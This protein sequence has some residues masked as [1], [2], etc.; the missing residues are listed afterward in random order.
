MY[1]GDSTEATPI[2]IP[3]TIQAI[4]N[5]LKLGASP[6]PMAVIIKKQSE[7]STSLGFQ[8]YH[9]TSR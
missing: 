9:L 1:I 8:I 6:V 7:I 3:P 2:T 5:M 4:M